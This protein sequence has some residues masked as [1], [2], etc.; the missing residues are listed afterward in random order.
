MTINLTDPIYQDADLARGHLEAI[1]WA[2]GVTCPKCGNADAARITKLQGKSTRPGVYKCKEC[3]KPFSVTV[4]TVFER[5][6]IP[7]NKWVIAVHLLTASKKGVS[8]HQLHRMLDVDYKTAWYMS[9]RI[10]DAMAD[11]SP[12]C[13]PLSGDGKT[14]EADET[15]FGPKDRVTKRTKHGKPGLASKRMVVGLVERGGH[16]RLFYVERGTAETVREVLVRHASRKSHLYTDD[17]RFYPVTGEEYAS[18]RTVTH[19]AG[20]YVRYN[21]DTVIH[22]NTNENVFSVLKRGMRGIYQH[23]GEAHLYRYLAEFEFRHNTR[24]ALGVEDN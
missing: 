15:Y 20:E 13:G 3:R 5:S 9:H 12:N 8:S 7:L 17:S 18:H 19:S 22:T 6:H 11:K 23:C 24:S 16:T 4:G 2:D 14:V 1:L 10:R 21:G